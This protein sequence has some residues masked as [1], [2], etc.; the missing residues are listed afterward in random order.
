MSRSDIPP[1]E[2]KWSARRALAFIVSVSAVLWA[3]I[4]CD[5]EEPSVP[6]CPGSRTEPEEWILCCG[7]VVS[8]ATMEDWLSRGYVAEGP[9]SKRG[10]RRTV[11]AGPK[12]DEWLG[13]RWHALIPSHDA[14]PL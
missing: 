3:L 5:D 7:H 9:P 13:E 2:P 1:A 4:G 6:L 14:G 11:V 10:H 12:I 8:V